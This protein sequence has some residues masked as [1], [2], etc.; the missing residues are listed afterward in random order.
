MR[1]NN[2]VQTK[3]WHIEAS[4]KGIFDLRKQPLDGPGDNAATYLSF[5]LMSP[6]SLD[7]L[8]LEPNVPKLDLQLQTD[9]GVQVWLNGK[10][11]S[12]R[13]RRG[14][15]EASWPRPRASAGMEQRS[16]ACGACPRRRQIPA[17]LV[18]SQPDFLN[19][20]K[21]ALQKTVVQK[22]S[23]PTNRPHAQVLHRS[24]N[25][26]RHL[27]RSPLRLRHRRH[28]RRGRQPQGLLCRSAP[29]R[30]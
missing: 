14:P 28:F 21:S 22:T 18:S 19:D 16:P 25:T 20:L 8:L 11:V 3:R 10:S 26:N 1:D 4:D 30:R 12:H 15:R 23:Q 7:N 5:W 9:D 29:H 2:E 24:Y 17:Q 27:G 6:R 13:P